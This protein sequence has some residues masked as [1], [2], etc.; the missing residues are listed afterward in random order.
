MSGRPPTSLLVARFV[1]VVA[2]LLTVRGAIAMITHTEGG[3]CMT[4]EIGRLCFKAVHTTRSAGIA[5]LF[6]AI[7]VTVVISLLLS[8]VIGQARRTR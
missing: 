3:G 5:V 7:V 1:V 2:G 8:Y 6:F 4:G